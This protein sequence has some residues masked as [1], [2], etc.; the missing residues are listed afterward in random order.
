MIKIK[1]KDVLFFR[2][3]RSFN[4]KFDINAETFFPPYPSTIYGALRTAY[5]MQ[6][7]SFEDFKNG[8][9][10]DIIGFP[11]E[12]G[13]DEKGSF[14]IKGIFLKNGDKVFLP[15]PIDL[16]K[17]KEGEE[18][19]VYRLRIIK[20]EVISNSKVEY[21]LVSPH[22][23]ENVKNLTNCFL[24]LDN[25][26]K[27]L[28]NEKINEFEFQNL[29]ELIIKEPKI[30]I[31]LNKNSKTTEKSYLYRYDFIRPVKGN[32]D[33]KNIEETFILVDYEGINDFDESF[34]FKVGG[35]GKVSKVEKVSQKVDSLL[36]NETKEIIKN[37]KEFKL[38]LATPS[39][40]NNGSIP[41]EK[42]DENILRYKDLKLELLTFSTTK[43]LI[44]SGWDINLNRPKKSMKMVAAGTVYYF[45]LIDG[46]PERIFEYFDYKNI[47]DVLPEEGFGLSFV[48]II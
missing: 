13:T 26:K 38:Y 31:K 3:G 20:N 29:E 35:E 32:L 23:K 43:N 47:S 27:Y 9:F 33:D 18:K 15:M 24:D 2:T 46:D 45:K 14:K 1:A 41:F 36:T 34:Y 16:V 30:G 21:L 37:K 17:T 6:K 8:K 48:G 28:N 10:K 44:Y 4:R 19:K 42:I 11:R 5:F 22:D 39:I 40:F 7:G 25:L 12:N